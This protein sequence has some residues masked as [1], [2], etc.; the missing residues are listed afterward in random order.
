MDVDGV[1]NDYGNAI[2][3]FVESREEDMGVGH[4]MKNLRYGYL[5]WDRS[6]VPATLSTY[7]RRPGDADYTGS[8][9]FS[10]GA[11]GQDIRQNFPYATIGKR[12]QR[13]YRNNVVDED[14]AL[15]NEI[16]YFDVRGVQP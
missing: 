1:L 6:G 4:L 8:G 9:T 12:F 5:E 14:M 13:K 11:V 10:F 2:D 16:L 3:A 7:F 15:M